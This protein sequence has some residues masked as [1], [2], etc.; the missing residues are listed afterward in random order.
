MRKLGSN[1]TK[2]ACKPQTSLQKLWSIRD[3]GGTSTKCL[4]IS[5]SLV[6]KLL[7][8][9]CIR[10]SCTRWAS[11]ARR[12]ILTACTW[13]SCGSRSRTAVKTAKTRKVQMMKRVKRRRETVERVRMRRKR[14]RWRWK[15]KMIRKMFA[16][17]RIWRCT[18][19]RF[20]TWILTT[21]QI[22][23][24]GMTLL[25]VWVR[26]RYSKLISI[27]WDWLKIGKILLWGPNLNFIHLL[28]NKKT[29]PNMSPLLHLWSIKAQRNK[30]K[31]MAVLNLGCVSLKRVKNT[32]RGKKWRI[33]QKNTI[34]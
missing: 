30:N 13:S 5:K 1:R 17:F 7:I 19:A 26:R 27:S 31:M 25:F 21:F 2:I 6:L 28:R 23:W 11:W 34:S 10:R 24:H 8:R 32:S 12:I 15:M 22:N 16:S 14:W 29:W 9:S 20:R 18:C 33:K 4:N 3:L